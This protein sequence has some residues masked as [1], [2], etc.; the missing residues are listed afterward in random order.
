MKNSGIYV[1]ADGQVLCDI[2]LT[3]AAGSSLGS[4]RVRSAGHTHTGVNS[5]TTADEKLELVIEDG[6][7]DCREWQW[8]ENHGYG[9]EMRPRS[10]PATSGFRRDASGVYVMSQYT[11]DGTRTRLEWNF[12]PQA[13]GEQMLSYD[14]EITIE[15]CSDRDLVEYG[16]FFACYTEINRDQSQFFWAADGTLRTFASFGGHHLDAYI[17]APG[18]DFERAG[19]IPHAAKGDGKVAHTWRQPVLVGHPTP[20]GWRH[21]VLTDPANTAGLASGMGGIAMDYIAWPGER[22]FRPGSSFSLKIRHYVVRT[23][24]AVDVSLVEALWSSFDAERL[25]G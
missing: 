12:A 19:A 4:C 24:P 22:V 14:C 17:V 16:Q 2:D 23:G 15:N 20:G 6:A 18:S 13:A 1:D 10:A 11:C 5:F 7:W 9:Q 3:D 25:S 8:W 21:I